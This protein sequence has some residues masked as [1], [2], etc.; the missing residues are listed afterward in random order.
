MAISLDGCEGKQDMVFI[1]PRND[2]TL[3]LGGLAEPNHQDLNINPHNYPPIK[4]MYTRCLEFYEPLRNCQIDFDYPAIA[5]GLRPFRKT[6][7]R[8]E[9]EPTGV[10]RGKRF[11][12]VYSEAL[13]SLYRLTAL[14]MLLTLLLRSWPRSRPIS[15]L[16]L[17]FSEGVGTEH[18]IS[19]FQWGLDL[20]PAWDRILKDNN[21]F[22]ALQGVI[23]PHHLEA[24]HN[25]RSVDIDCRNH[26]PCPLDTY[27]V[28]R[29]LSA[30]YC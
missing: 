16:W 15:R 25:Y 12:I 19:A 3:I 1:V 20:V 10:Y 23:N 18:H 13:D 28:S 22:V 29:C 7:V 9:R 17:G 5:V 30:S 24:N 26:T 14:L 21:I 4:A 6:N 8:I 11:R 2:D 27:R